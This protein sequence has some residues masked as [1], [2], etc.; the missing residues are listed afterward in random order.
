VRNKLQFTGATRFVQQHPT[1]PGNPAVNPDPEDLPEIAKSSLMLPNY[2][3]DI[4]S[5]NS[6]PSQDVRLRG[7][8]VAGVLDVRGN[9]SI[10]GV[11]LL[12]F[13]PKL[14]EGPL[15]DPLGNSAGNPALFNTTLGYFGPEDGDEE[16]LDPL[17]LPIVSIGGVPTKIVGYDVD[18]DGL[19]DVGPTGAPPPGSTPVPFYGYGGIN[20]RFDEELVLPDGLVIPLQMDVDRSSYREA[21]K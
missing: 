17:T 11:L 19:P 7:A 1:E 8:I 16:S 18:G 14:G 13:K 3:V 20:M 9:A 12:T 2:S 4:G 21:S 10:D 15:Q 6:P 5:F